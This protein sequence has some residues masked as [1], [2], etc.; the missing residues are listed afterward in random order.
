MKPRILAADD[1]MK[2]LTALKLLLFA[3]GMELESVTT[4]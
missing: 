3:E 2:V 1:D 4:P